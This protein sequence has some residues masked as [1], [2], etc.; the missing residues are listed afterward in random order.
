MPLTP[1]LIRP[2][3]PALQRNAIFFDNPGGTQVA[4]QTVDRVTRYLVE[5]NANHG[6]AFASSQASDA[7]IDEARAA[8]ADFYNAADPKEIVFGANMTSL[9]FAFSRAFARTLQRGDTLVVTRLD[10]DANIAPWMQIA[11]DRGARLEW[12]DFDVED[13]TLRLETFEKAL[14][15]K[16]KLVAVGYASNAL[17]TINPVKQITEMAHQAGA[18]VYVDAVQYAPHGSIDVQDLGCDILVSSAYKYFSTHVGVLY[19]RHSLLE[20]LRPY[21][22]RPSSNEPPGKWE[23]GTGN[24]EG[25]AGV[26]GAMEYFEMLGK[27]ENGGD[28]RRARLVRAM[29]AIQT[30]EQTLSKALIH[31]LQQIPGLHLFGLQDRTRLDERVPTFSFTL[32]GKHPRQVAEK[33]AEDGICVW[34]GNYYALSVTERL[35]VEDK[36][37]M[38]RV[39]AVHYNTLE[40]VEKL[41]EVLAGIS[42]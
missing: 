5:T 31:T 2:H 26:L 33:L 39:G 1:S 27:T 10:H 12:V 16:P 41:G 29:T 32:A 42:P 17:G 37:G 4:Q 23:T 18:L 3:F 13:G 34:D 35:G 24:F 30:Y 6:G 28:T 21:K 40:E 22:V 14:E 20:E 7:I 25:I 38:V 36:G 11:E 15:T 9:T 19:A 8:C